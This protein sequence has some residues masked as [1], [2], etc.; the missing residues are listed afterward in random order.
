MRLAVGSATSG[1]VS[2]AITASSSSTAAGT[3]SGNDNNNG[4]SDNGTGKSGGLSTAAS[5]GI[6]VGVGV[7]GLLL[8]GALVWFLI[9]YRKRSK[10]GEAQFSPT[11]MDDPPDPAPGLYHKGELDGSQQQK[12]HQSQLQPSS[13]TPGTIPVVKTPDDDYPTRPSTTVVSTEDSLLEDHHQY[14]SVSAFELQTVENLHQRQDVA[15]DMA[16]LSTHRR[17]AHPEPYELQS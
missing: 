3:S 7:V 4:S 12:Q 16:E 10:L 6:G 8:L 14:S 5:V 2:S 11:K 13:Q 1:A 15:S 9:H 17:P